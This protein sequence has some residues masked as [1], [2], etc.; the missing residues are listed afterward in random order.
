V[1]SASAETQRLP[2]LD[3]LK[4][5]AIIGVVAIHAFPSDAPVYREH[6]LNGVARLAVPLFLIISGFL[7][8]SRPPSRARALRY[9]WKFLRLH[10][11]YGALYWAAQPLF[12]VP[13]APITPK[14]AVMH[15]AAFSYAGQF[16]LFV[17]PQIYFVMALLVPERLWGSKQLLLGSLLLAAGT[18]AL[19][20]WCF[21]A[22]GADP[23]LRKLAGQGEA[24]ASLWLFPFCLGMW[25]GRRFAR[26]PRG[27]GGGASCAV[28]AIL[29]VAVAALDLPATAGGGYDDAFPY[30][31][32][33]IGIGAALSAFTLPW[34][35]RGLGLP[36]LAAIGRESFGI[37]VLNPLILGLLRRHLGDVATLS[38]SL[39]YTAVTLGIA[40][41]L[42]RLLRR[43]IPF[44]FA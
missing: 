19:V 1:S 21:G 16:F 11:L 27:D 44:A 13:Y 33:S 3:A 9:F 34:A 39:L 28:L 8:G 17:L 42:T 36:P 20:V 37:F 22:P 40:W 10:I 32:W 23:L 12:G 6:V 15:F 26:S 30:V 29:A 41:L 24:S 14:S 18:S 2:G 43:R 38:E 7:L 35:S 5:I 25:V 31:R 4:G